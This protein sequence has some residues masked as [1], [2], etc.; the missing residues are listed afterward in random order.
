MVTQSK[1]KGEAKNY[2][3]QSIIDAVESTPDPDLAKLILFTSNR[4]DLYYNE[5]YREDFGVSKESVLEH[6]NLLKERGLIRTSEGVTEEFN[7]AIVYE[8]VKN[9]YLKSELP[10]G[11][12]TVLEKKD[13]PEPKALEAMNSVK[14]IVKFYYSKSFIFNVGQL[15]EL[16]EEV[17]NRIKEIRKFETSHWYNFGI[18]GQFSGFPTFVSE[19]DPTKSEYNTNVNS[20]TLNAKFL[21][22]KEAFRVGFDEARGF[23]LTSKPYKYMNEDT[24]YFLN[25]ISIHKKDDLYQISLANIR[26]PAT[27][28]PNLDHNKE[29]KAVT[30]TLKGKLETVLGAAL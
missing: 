27:N 29:A 18:P 3:L 17:Y 10:L 7:K 24:N 16:K 30:E 21:S 9:L 15:T 1:L 11:P 13:V 6:I 23:P 4:G 8:E 19:K 20:F 25:G 12:Y 26:Y 2:I 22:P 14:D 5:K 28:I